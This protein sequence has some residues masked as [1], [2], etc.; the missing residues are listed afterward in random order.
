MVYRCMRASRVIVN[1]FCTFRSYRHTGRYTVES[2]FFQSYIWQST[3]AGFYRRYSTLSLTTRYNWYCKISW[4]YFGLKYCMK[5]LMKYFENFTKGLN[6]SKWDFSSC[7]SIYRYTARLVSTLYCED[8][9]I[10]CDHV[11]G[12]MRKNM[13]RVLRTNIIIT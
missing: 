8:R 6:I 9:T 2:F 1:I 4:Y 13:L 10:E 11:R 7:T 3:V 5:Y 12:I